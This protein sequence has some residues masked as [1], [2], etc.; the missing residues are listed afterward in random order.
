MFYSR[1]PWVIAFPCLMYLSSMGRFSS[2]PRAVVVLEFNF[3][4]A[5]M[6]IL[7]SCPT[8][9]RLM[10]SEWPN[11]AFYS[12]SLSLNIILTLMIVIRLVLHGRNTFAV[13]TSGSP[14]GLGNLYKTI[15]TMLIESCALFAVSSLL[16]IVPWAVGSPSTFL[17]SPIFAEIQV[18]A[19]I[20]PRSLDGLPNM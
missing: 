4:N 3:D 1:N 8:T 19:F 12:I 17:F 18:R 13:T 11:L 5:V 14:T 16:L 20:R 15:A 2:F 7:L 9:D 6:G 10:H